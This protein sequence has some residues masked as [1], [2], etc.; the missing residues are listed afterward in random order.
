VTVSQVLIVGAALTFH[1]LGGIITGGYWSRFD[2]P[3]WHSMSGPWRP[4]IRAV[5]YPVMLRSG[6][7][8][9]AVGVGLLFLGWPLLLHAERRAKAAEGG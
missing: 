1:G 2:Y 3:F 4:R 8:L 6:A 9:L 7:A 5:S